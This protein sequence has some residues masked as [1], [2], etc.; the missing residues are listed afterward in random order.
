[1]F[2]NLPSL[3]PPTSSELRDELERYLSSD[4]EHTTDAL[5][6]WYDR[7]AVYPTLSRMALDYLSIPATSVNVE[8]TFSRGRLLLLYVRNRLSAQ[9]TRALMCLG[10][11]SAL[12][13]IKDDDALAVAQLEEVEGDASD[14]EMEEGWDDIDL[15]TLD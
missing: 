5:K 12:D 3:A 13:L 6:W 14:Y 2:N 11:W 7:R 15:T 4:P 10:N 8:R 1:I 9:T